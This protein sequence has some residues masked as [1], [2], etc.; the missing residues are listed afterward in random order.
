MQPKR[1]LNVIRGWGGSSR[2]EIPILVLSP[3][4]P[5]YHAGGLH[6][7]YGG[8]WPKGCPRSGIKGT[9]LGRNTKHEMRNSKYETDSHLKFQSYDSTMGVI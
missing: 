8:R 2:V 9:A 7:Q 4:R 3:L 6:F 1:R 5:S